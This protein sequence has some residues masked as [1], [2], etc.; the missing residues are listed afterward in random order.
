[1]AR[2]SENLSV[3]VPAKEILGHLPQIYS[4]FVARIF[5]GLVTI[6]LEATTAVG[7]LPHYS[8]LTIRMNALLQDRETDITVDF[9]VAP[10]LATRVCYLL[11]PS[12]GIGSC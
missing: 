12:G 6:E 1:M 10:A 8:C 7:K 3:P 4:L 11:L 5:L 2:E 9:Y